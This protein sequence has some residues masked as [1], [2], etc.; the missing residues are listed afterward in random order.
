MWC[1]Y[2]SASASRRGHN[3]YPLLLGSFLLLFHVL[4]D[5]T[6]SGY[7]SHPAPLAVA[8]VA[9]GAEERPTLPGKGAEVPRLHHRRET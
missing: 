2:R 1:M 4:A 3:P 8:V 5:G 6:H 9:A 7:Y